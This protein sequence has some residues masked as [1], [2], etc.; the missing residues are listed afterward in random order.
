MN[1]YILKY[2]FMN[3]WHRKLRSL[4]TIVSIFI[5][6]MALFALRS[7]GLGLE[8]F[9]E[10][11]AEQMGTDKII[12]QPSGF[13]GF[14]I[15]ITRFSDKD[16]RFIQKQAG[17]DVATGVMMTVGELKKDDQLRYPYVAG[18]VFEGEES[19]LIEETW[20]I[21]ILEG[22]GLKDDEKNRAVL[23]YNYLVPN[24]VF[25]E[26]VR[27]R[28]KITLNDQ[29]IQ[30]VGFYEQIGNPA[31]DMN[32][33]L[34]M[35]GFKDIF[36]RE[37]EY[38]MLFARTETGADPTKVAEDLEDR[39]RRFKDQEEGEEDFA[40]TTFQEYLEAFTSIFDILNIILLSIVGIAS[41]VAAVN[42]ANT[43]YTS[44]LERTNE[45]GIMKAIG[46]KNFFILK[47]FLLEGAIQGIM[48]GL[49]GVLIGYG[50]GRLGGYLTTQ[51]GVSM[52]Q[53][54]FP[55][56]LFAESLI[57]AF[58]MATISSILPAYQAAKLNPVDALRYE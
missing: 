33:Y 51:L 30:V 25:K 54:R 13:G 1:L 3:L 39:F 17:I 19:E 49:I 40:I 11:F 15:G 37:D 29:E 8:F 24:R 26:P 56:S 32:V 12:V 6:I 41:V 50:I 14:S 35:D 20:T 16:L 42:I 4:L 10:D 55:V 34:T 45:I 43:M 38:D 18:Q 23:G 46:A 5:G 57:L 22:R 36:G 31:D 28:E 47:I 58:L 52:L 53:P 2:A 27:L 44:T 9:V 21:S 48:G 7:F